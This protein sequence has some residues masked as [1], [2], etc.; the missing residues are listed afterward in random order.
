VDMHGAGAGGVEGKADD[1]TET[2]QHLRARSPGSWAE[3]GV[4]T[5]VQTV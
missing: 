2:V 3:A 5:C 1:E 4:S